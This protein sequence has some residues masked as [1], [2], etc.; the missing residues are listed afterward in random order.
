MCHV[1]AGKMVSHMNTACCCE[2][3]CPVLLPI[4]DEIRKL[5]EHRKIVQE[6]IEAI[7]NKIVSLKSL[8]V[9]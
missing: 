2:C 3:G 7:D 8:K 9:P 1:S 4:E 6:Q 5:E